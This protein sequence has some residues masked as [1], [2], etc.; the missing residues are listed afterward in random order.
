MDEADFIAGT[1]LTA[2][3][4][5]TDMSSTAECYDRIH[6]RILFQRQAGYHQ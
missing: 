2:K 3:T 6:D 5:Y 4:S 1:I